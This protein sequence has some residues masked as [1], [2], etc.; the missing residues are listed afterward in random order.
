M[1]K[2][3]PAEF[4]RHAGRVASAWLDF[5][6]RPPSEGDGRLQGLDSGKAVDLQVIMGQV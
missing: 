2:A 1:A 5:G 4:D 3:A 6:R